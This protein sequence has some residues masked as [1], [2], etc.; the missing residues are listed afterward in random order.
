MSNSRTFR[1]TFVFVLAL[2]YHLLPA[3]TVYL[4]AWNPVV[5]PNPQTGSCGWEVQDLATTGTALSP[6]ASWTKAWSVITTNNVANQT[7]QFLSDAYVQGY[8][9]DGP[10]NP[11]IDNCLGASLDAGATVTS[12]LNG[13]TVQG[14]TSGCGTLVDASGQGGNTLRFLN[15]T[16][17]DNITVKDIHF[18]GFSQVITINNSQNILFENCSFEGVNHGITA[19][20]G[21]LINSTTRNTSVTFTNCKFLDNKYNTTTDAVKIQSSS[22][23]STV[24]TEVTFTDCD[25]ICNSKDNSG[26]AVMITGR[27]GSANTRTKVT[28]TRGNFGGN[29]STSHYGSAVYV[30]NNCD[31]SFTGTKFLANTVNPGGTY[32]LSDGGGAIYVFS[33]NTTLTSANR[34]LVTIR[35]CIFWGN[36]FLGG[37]TPYGGALVVNGSSSQTNGAAGNAPRVIVRNCIFEKNRAKSGRGGAIWGRYADLSIDRCYFYRDSAESRGG[38]IWTQSG[39][40]YEVDSCT[41]ANN[42]S[43]SGADIRND[44]GTWT[45]TNSSGTSYV[46]VS[47]TGSTTGWNG[48]YIDASVFMPNYTCGN[49]C[50]AQIPGTCLANSISNFY[51]TPPTATGSISGAAFFDTNNDGINN[52]GTPFVNAPILL[53]DQNNNIIGRTFADASGNYSFTGLPS[54]TY[55]VV[56]VPNHTIADSLPTQQNAAGSSPS[57]DSDIG[58]LY[59]TGD[60]VINTSLSNTNSTDSNA[61]ALNITNVTGGFSSIPAVFPLTLLGFNGNM[62]DCSTQRLTW[63]TAQEEMVSHF[64]VLKSTD[65]ENFQKVGRVEAKGNHLANQT[66]TYVFE[67]EQAEAHAFYQLLSVD[68]DQ[69]SMASDVIETYN[70]CVIEAFSILQNPVNETVDFKFYLPFSREITIAVFDCRGVKVAEEKRYVTLGSQELNLEVNHLPT[71]VYALQVYSGNYFKS[72]KFIKK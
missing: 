5:Y 23:T 32:S 45:L 21:I 42:V 25:F 48:S 16:G 22:A 67:V 35:D 38:A 8:N 7:V 17:A 15:I 65:A 4:G 24:F 49:Y 36:K 59:S 30:G 60:L 39:G 20:D 28:F 54:G 19:L 18:K 43:A 56:F 55:H 6:F 70:D 51:C 66:N 31:V 40:R 69:S 33:D 64:E 3:Q 1:P 71:G 47:N 14:S 2:A 72:A 13:L 41:F 29:I 50:I 53:Y 26:G 58:A 68:I 52:D 9:Y 12:V 61:P 46:S 62:A 34:T 10:A 63:L 27:T 44:G 11:N 57:N 37:S